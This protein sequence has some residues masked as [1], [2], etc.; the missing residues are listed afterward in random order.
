[1]I[2]DSLQKVIKERLVDGGPVYTETTLEHLNHL[3]VEPW[4]AYSSL[5]FLLPP[6]Y[7]GFKLRGR[8]KDYPFITFCLPFMVLG[9]LGSTLF[10]AFRTSRWLLIMDFMPIVVITIGLTV[11]FWAK[12]L[13]KWSYAIMALIIMFTISMPV[14]AFVQGP[15]RINISYFIRGTFM[16]LPMVLI[17]RKTQF[18]NAKLLVASILLFIAALA[19][20]QFDYLDEIAAVMPMGIHWMW[21]IFTVIG[22]FTLA[23]YVYRFVNLEKSSGYKD[24]L[25][26]QQD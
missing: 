24:E 3:V 8:Y 11:Y 22:A 1:M 23:E 9:G 2:P 16:F 25:S 4:N 5:F 14:W 12:A 6:L 7:W 17:L 26:I 13:G 18:A 19:C 10:H 20:R 21:H 15:L